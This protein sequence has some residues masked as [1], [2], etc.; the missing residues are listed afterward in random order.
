MS[1][2]ANIPADWKQFKLR[3]G[4]RKW[5]PPWANEP[6]K[7]TFDPDKALRRAAFAKLPKTLPSRTKPRR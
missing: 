3:N 2:P 6:L 1:R 4:E 5:L 7:F